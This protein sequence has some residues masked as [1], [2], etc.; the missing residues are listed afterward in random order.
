MI[1]RQCTN[2]VDAVLA[3]P[4]VMRV[5]LTDAHLTIRR[6]PSHIMHLVEPTRLPPGRNKSR[7]SPLEI[8]SP[9]RTFD[10]RLVTVV[11]LKRGRIA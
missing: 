6:R 7:D 2:I 5:V 9:R 11:R 4:G 3:M 1:N 8:H 10:E